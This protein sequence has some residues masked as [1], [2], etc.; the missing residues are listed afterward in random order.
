VKN[1]L[2]QE[3]TQSLYERARQGDEIA[4]NE[5]CGILRAGLI[6]IA[7][8]R[9]RGWAR[10]SIEDIVQE[11]L[12]TFI[13]KMDQVTSSPTAFARGILY[14]KI[15]NELRQHEQQKMNVDIDSPTAIAPSDADHQET[16]LHHI[17]KHDIIDKCT[18]A[19]RNM[20]N[21]CR[22]MLIA[23]LFGFSVGELWTKMQR[24]EP[25][26]NRS[27]FDRRLYRC[28]RRLLSLIGVNP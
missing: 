22:I 21:P 18:N 4:L 16:V 19:I 25:Q 2:H 14:K 11:T 23:M 9:L 5:Y 10:H 20:P 17:E 1:S 3:E 8:A 26:L 6:Q 13:Q 12:T 27:A 24:L 15:G 28:R 7:S